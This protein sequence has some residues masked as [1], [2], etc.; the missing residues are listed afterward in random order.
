MY[1]IGQLL[2][3]VVAMMAIV[4]ECSGMTGAD[5]AA[6]ALSLMVAAGIYFQQAMMS[7]K[8]RFAVMAAAIMNAGLMLLWRSMGLNAPEFYLVP[9]G[10]SVLGLVEMLKKELPKSSHDPLRYIGAL[11]ILVS[12]MFE[13]LGG[14]WAHMLALMV[15]SV[16]VILLAIGLRL[17]ALVYAGSAFLLADL[18]AMVVR[19]TVSHPSLLW[20]CGIVLGGGVIALAAFCENHREK[21]LARIRLVSAELA[22]WG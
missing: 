7:H 10:L 5:T 17:R 14:S 3:T 11:I 21:L 19:T 16:V 15:L 2:P 1:A 20:V 12:P 6:N 18:V 4:R 8:R 9:V 13:V 22:T